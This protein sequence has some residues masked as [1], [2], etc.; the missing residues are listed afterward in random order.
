MKPLLQSAT[1]EESAS[2]ALRAI[3]ERFGYSRYKMNRFEDYDFYV[4]NK[5]FLISDQVITFTD[6]T[7]FY[8]HFFQFLRIFFHADVQL[9]H[10]F[11]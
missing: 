5:D 2:F 8:N 11:R 9:L 3:Y 6:T 4:R 10:F 7:G 1:P